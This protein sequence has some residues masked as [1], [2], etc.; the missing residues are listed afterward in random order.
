M[1]GK[2]VSRGQ[3]FRTG[4]LPVRKGIHIPVDARCAGYRPRLT[5]A[6]GPRVEQRA[7]LARTR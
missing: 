4:F 7:F 3:A 6:Q 2:S 1:G 5:A